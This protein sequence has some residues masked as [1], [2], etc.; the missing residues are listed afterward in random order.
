M[1]L[2]PDAERNACRS[3]IQKHAQGA[4]LFMVTGAGVTGPDDER[5]EGSTA[6]QVEAIGDALH[7]RAQKTALDVR[8]LIRHAPSMLVDRIEWNGCIRWQHQ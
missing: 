7:E 6:A 3:D 1:P 2:S 8:C 5:T 4:S